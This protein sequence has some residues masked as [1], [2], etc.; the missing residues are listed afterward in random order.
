M[1]I[2]AYRRHHIAKRLVV[3]SHGNLR[4]HQFFYKK[5]AVSK[6]FGTAFFHFTHY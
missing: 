2:V 1:L 5:E 3:R 6:L 4:I